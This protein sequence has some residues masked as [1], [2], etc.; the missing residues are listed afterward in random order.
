LQAKVYSAK[1]PL[2]VARRKKLKHP[3]HVSGGQSSSGDPFPSSFMSF[4]QIS[5]GGGGGV[6]RSF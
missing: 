1:H 4:P 5:S 2:L 3:M 6:A